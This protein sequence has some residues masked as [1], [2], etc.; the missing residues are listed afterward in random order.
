[1][2]L[3]A[4]FNTARSSLQATSTRLSVSA[5]NVGS[6]DSASASRKIAVVTTSA[7]G[8]AKVVTI[9]RAS[10]SAL[11]DKMLSS[12]SSSAQLKALDDGLTVLQKT[13]GDTES[14]TSPAALLGTFSNALT[15]AANAPDDTALAA[16]AVSAAQDLA[17]SLNDACDAVQ[18]VR[19]DADSAIAASVG[20]VNDLLSQFQDANDAVVRGT[21]L[22][23]DVTNALDQRD[24]ILAQLAEEMGISTLTRDNN[25]I[26]IYTDSGVTLFDKTARSVTFAESGMLDAS[27]SGNAVYVD[28][29]AVAGPGASTSMALKS[30]TIV[31][32]TTLRDDVAVTYQAQ[33]DEVARG[34][35]DTFAETDQSGLGGPT[36]AGLFTA[37]AGDTSVP[38]SMV[39]GLA[40][41]ITVNAAVDTEQGG[42]PFA[43]RDGGMNG[44]SH[45]YNTG[46]EASYGTRLTSLVDTLAQSRTYDATAQLHDGT[47]LM[48]FA[49]SSVS[50]LEGQRSTVSSQLDTQAAVLS[51]ASTALSSATGVNLDEEYALQLELERSYQASSKL[52]GVVSNLYDQL[53]SVIG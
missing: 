6:A 32:L 14:E 8:G 28:G 44:A 49:T 50:W 37:S 11:F 24:S 1:M 5:S 35:I 34:L 13:V 16:A 38:G 27:S 52:I 3:T 41:S 30:G 53:F 25:D 42:T 9:T 46:A 21:A 45:L 36:M 10:D 7:D 26:A 23:T 48:G 33:L 22:G 17:V 19:T 47:N 29:V 51:Q 2:S 18:Q 31:G 40:G 4:A 20:N 12:T 15:A 43:L 39:A